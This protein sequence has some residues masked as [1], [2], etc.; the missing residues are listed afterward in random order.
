MKH[1]ISLFFAAVCAF[2][3]ASKPPLPPAAVAHNSVGTQALAE[4]DLET[5]GANLELAL[6]YNPEFVEAVS[7]LGLVEMERGNF[8]R[9]RQLFE[10]ARR[11]NPDIAQ[12]HH[13][14]GVLAEKEYRLEEASEHYRS[15]LAVDPGFAASRANLARLLLEAGHYE[16]ALEQFRKLLQVAPDEVLARAGYVECLMRLGRTEEAFSV[17]QEGKPELAANPRLLVLEA[18]LELRAGRPRS[19]RRLLAPLRQRRDD[20]GVEAR[21]WL[22]VI[23]LSEDDP[24]TALQLA[25]E[26]LELD[27]EHPL[28]LFATAVSLD[29]LNDPAAPAWLERANAKNPD[30]PELGRRIASH[31]N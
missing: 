20:H 19:A 7:N 17:I 16:H 21:A 27:P 31:R 9:A 26:A 18:R 13:S 14:L 29:T 11:L 22:A 15:A 10:R 1:A 5:A 12:P 6:E 23:S 30:N 28:T 8:A 24:E 3:C 2:A 25:R 4:G